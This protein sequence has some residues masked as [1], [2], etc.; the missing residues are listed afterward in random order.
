MKTKTC[1][2]CGKDYLG[3][4]CNECAESTMTKKEKI[5][6]LNTAMQTK[7]RGESGERETFQC[8]NDE[9]PEELKMLFMKHYEVR[10]LDYETF[11]QACDLVHDMYI[12]QPD[13]SGNDAEEAIYERSS[14]SADIYT[15]ERLAYLKNWNEDEVVDIMSEY[16]ERS[17]S[18][19][20]A[21]WYDKQVE[22]A[23]IIIN[24]WV[25][26]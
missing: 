1:E 24:E 8:F 19:A 12:D 5:I 15:S 20:C 26:A 9:A 3:E 10:D 11:S 16:G 17:I 4:K 21:I 7:V 14:D 23:A 6:A 2:Q 25:N 13:A 18:T 22:Q